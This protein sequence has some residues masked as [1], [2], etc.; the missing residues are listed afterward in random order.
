MCL[1]RL[2]LCEYDSSQYLQ[3]CFTGRGSETE[4]HAVLVDKLATDEEDL[5]LAVSWF[6]LCQ[7]EGEVGSWLIGGETEG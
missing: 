3:L 7:V 5:F 1:D 4:A 6:C 2:L